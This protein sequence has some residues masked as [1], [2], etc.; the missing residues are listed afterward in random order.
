M[1]KPHNV[2]KKP[3]SGPS[4]KKMKAVETARKEF[5]YCEKGVLGN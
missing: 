3:K 4:T 1:T 2:C 5:S